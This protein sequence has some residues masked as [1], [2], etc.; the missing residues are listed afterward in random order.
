MSAIWVDDLFSLA[1]SFEELQRRVEEVQAAFA[2][3]G[4]ELSGSSLGCFRNGRCEGA[5]ALRLAR[6]GRTFADFERLRV[7]GIVLDASGS[8]EAMSSHRDAEA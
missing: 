2:E 4:L 8:T 5:R 6:I 3:L 7:L 1:D